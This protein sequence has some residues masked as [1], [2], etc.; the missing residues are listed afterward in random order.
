MP[1]TLFAIAISGLFA[2]FFSPTTHAAES[3][4][5]R[6]LILGYHEVEPD[7][8]PAHEVIP[9]ELAAAPTPNEMDMYT[10]S[11]AT[12]RQQL[13]ALAAHGFTAISFAALHEFLTGARA[14][15][16][17]KSVVITADDG[18]R[19]AKTEMW[20]EL[21]KRG[22]PFTIFVYPRVIDRHDHHPFNLT[23]DDV[24]VLSKD[25]VDVESHTYAHPFL[26]R[27]KHPELDDEHY[28]DW[29]ESELAG[30]RRLITQHTGREVRFL[31]YPYGDYDDAV[32]AAAKAA[33]YTEAVTVSPGIVMRSDPPFTLH[34]YL[35]FHG[36]T[37]QEFERWLDG[38]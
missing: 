20:P 5:P 2:A 4:N 21:K 7:G 24:A 25:G 17:E 6:I 38:R 18:W 30:S 32:I 26:S 10:T 29:L 12:F 8:V 37:M 9:R 19:S 13:D 34:R 31:A 15:L 36:T 27:K 16:P 1:R 28:R 14:T 23:W 33:G 35:V 22:Y 11:T 3:A